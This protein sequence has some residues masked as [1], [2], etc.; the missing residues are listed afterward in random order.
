MTFEDR[1]LNYIKKHEGVRPKAYKD[2]LGIPTVGVG[3][4]LH[5]PDA[6]DIFKTLG[7]D[8]DAVL[9]GREVLTMDQVNKLLQDDLKVCIDDLKVLFKDWDTRPDE[10]KLVLVDMR[11]QLGGKGLRN[12][13]NT[14]KYL[15]NK[16]YKEAG[17]NMC[18]SLAYT[19]TPKRWDENIQLLA[20]IK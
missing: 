2:S 17:D 19:Q 3:F 5:R 20:S 11:F 12:F 10:F 16:Q 8:Y 1:L 18:K 13:K 7:I 6:R 14:L 15:T 9:K 4:N